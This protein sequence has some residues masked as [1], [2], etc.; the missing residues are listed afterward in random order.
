MSE[1][2]DDLTW[3]A[4]HT[5]EVLLTVN[6]HRASYVTAK[7]W[8]GNLDLAD[9]FESP[10]DLQK[11]IDTDTLVRVQVYPDTPVGFFV[12]CGTDV[13]RCIKRMRA[14]CEADRRVKCPG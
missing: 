1:T 13:A 6:D 4:E 8:I 10:E 3:L 14:I 2:M 5:H 11:A 7:E 12:V 9:D